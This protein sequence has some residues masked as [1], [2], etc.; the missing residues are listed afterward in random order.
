MV[1]KSILVERLED[2]ISKYYK[3]LLL[4]GAIY[5]VSIFL[6]ALIIFSSIEY[7]GRFNTLTRSVLFWI[8]VLLNV[9]VFYRWVAVPLRG[10]Y[11]LGNSLSHMQAARIIGQH[12]S[13]VEDR[14]INLLQLQELS[15]EDNS[16]INA[17]VNQKIKQLHPIR[18]SKA[19][20]LSSNN[21]PASCCVASGFF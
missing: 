17:S 3:N 16:L 11:R 9:I 2:F 6:F 13:S 15:D 21:G 14:L 5:F 12:F 10:L 1:E 18:F 19:I 20:T 7:F 8:F 4:K